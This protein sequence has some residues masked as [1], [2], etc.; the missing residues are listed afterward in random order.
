VPGYRPWTAV[1]IVATATTAPAQPPIPPKTFTLKVSNPTLGDVLR[2][3][4]E[5]TGLTVTAPG[6]DRKTPCPAPFD[7]TPF[8]SALDQAAAKTGAKIVL[9]DHGR[10]VTLAKRTGPPQPSSVDGPFRVAVRQVNPRLDYDTGKTFVDLTLDVH[11]EPRFPVFRL[12]GQPTLTA[13]AAD[14]G[15]PTAQPVKAMTA[16]T[17]CLFTTTVRIEGVPRSATKLTRVAGRFDVTA[18]PAMLPFVFENLAGPFPVVGKPPPGSDPRVSAVLKR[19]EPVSDLWEAEI[20]VTYPKG[21]EFESFESWVTENR[22]RLVSPG[23]QPLASADHEHGA[24]NSRVNGVYRFKVRP[25]DRKGWSLVYETPA[26]LVEFPVT[27][28]LKDIPLP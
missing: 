15:T 9:G 23:N 28:D 16:P 12:D 24:S 1:L 26:P 20:D 5:Q 17:G 13:L 14:A 2:E 18:S 4:P 21:P 22:A 7:R 10:Q 19:F 27:F 6:L 25:G 3:L 8:W 11:W